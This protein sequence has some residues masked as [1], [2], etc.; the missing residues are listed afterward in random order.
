[1]VRL[2]TSS[3]ST[4]L[5]CYHA[6]ELSIMEILLYDQVL[7]VPFFKRLDCDKIA[8][9]FASKSDAFGSE[10]EVYQRQGQVARSV[11]EEV[12]DRNRLACKHN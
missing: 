6:V 2:L 9:P 3:K 4:E 8:I 5:K 11:S 10:K 12:Q 1:M 7:N